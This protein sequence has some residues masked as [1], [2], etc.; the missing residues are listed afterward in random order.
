MA[1]QCDPTAR[2][3]A[4]E[5]RAQASLNLVHPDGLSE[6]LSRYI[7]WE[8]LAH[9]AHPA[10]ERG[11]PLP[12]QVTEELNRRCPGFLE[13]DP[14]AAQDSQGGSAARQ[15]LMTWI[16]NQMASNQ[17]SLFASASTDATSTIRRS[18]LRS[19]GVQLSAYS[20]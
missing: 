14:T 16:G 7:D 12:A 5:R 20:N 3:V 4:H 18:R 9:W 13:E 2:L 1:R 10:L 15:R 6:A 19:I 17:A 11:C 8:A